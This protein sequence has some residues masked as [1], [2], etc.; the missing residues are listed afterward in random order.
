[1]NNLCPNCKCNPNVVLVLWTHQRKD[2]RIE[3]DAVIRLTLTQSIHSFQTYE[4][5]K[6]YS[7]ELSQHRP[8]SVNNAIL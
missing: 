5:N 6:L 2:R 8:R 7:Q 3:A 1:M 4:M